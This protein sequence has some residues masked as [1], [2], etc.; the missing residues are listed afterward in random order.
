MKMHIET[1]PII[2][3]HEPAAANAVADT[4]AW[5]DL[6]DCKGLW[7]VVDHY[8]GGD[9]DLTCE[10]H[11][12][13]AASGTT[14]VANNFQIWYAMVALTDPTLVKQAD[15]KTFTIDTGSGNSTVAAKLV[16]Y[17]DSSKCKRYV[18]L[19]ASG[20]NAASIAAV[21]YI[22]DGFRYQGDQCF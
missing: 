2:M 13:D 5:A 7:I 15:A 10:V 19:G 18:Q 8:T 1:N 20:G 4:S 22:K 17:L 12:G 3:A 14:A 21:T 16:F 11:E 6:K 9:T